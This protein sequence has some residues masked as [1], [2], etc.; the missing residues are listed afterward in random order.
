MQSHAK[1]T[2][3]FLE[4]NTNAKYAGHQVPPQRGGVEQLLLVGYM[5]DSLNLP[6][7]YLKHTSWCRCNYSSRNFATQ[8]CR[9]FRNFHQAWRLRETSCR[10]DA[11][12]HCVGCKSDY[13]DEQQINGEGTARSIYMRNAGTVPLE[14]GPGRKCPLRLSRPKYGILTV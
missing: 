4:S 1:P 14:V 8:F 6:T 3:A 5:E 7:Y 13:D 10:R 12:R 9:L 2:C 11:V